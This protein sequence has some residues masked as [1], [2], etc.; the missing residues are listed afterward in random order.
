MNKDITMSIRIS[1][2][3]LEKLKRVASLLNYS[4]Y[5]EFV[6]RTVLNEADRVLAAQIT[7]KEETP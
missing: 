6:R 1:G 2:D 3:E 4:S 7:K 5:S